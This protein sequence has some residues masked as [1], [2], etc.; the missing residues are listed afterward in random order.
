MFMSSGFNE[1]LD[2]TD[3]ESDTKETLVEVEDEDSDN[4]RDT[5]LMLNMP[6]IHEP[7]KLKEVPIQHACYTTYRALLFYMYSGKIDFGPLKSRGKALGICSI[8]RN[9]E[10][11][12]DVTIADTFSHGYTPSAFSSQ[13]FAGL[14]QHYL[15]VSP[16][17][18]YKLAHAYGIDHLKGLALQSIVDQLTPDNILIEVNSPFSA[19]YEEVRAKEVEYWVKNWVCTS[20]C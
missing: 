10:V 15:K 14:K 19:G 1:S 5:A 7:I 13:S 18:M 12:E 8:A 4:D 9:K 20:P 6:T 11:D 2:I 16:K 17:S 3:R